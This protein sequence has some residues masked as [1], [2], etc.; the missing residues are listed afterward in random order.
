MVDKTEMGDFQ[1]A[2]TLETLDFYHAL[3]K[4]KC[5]TKSNI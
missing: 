3:A 4:P 5:M 2:Q 1:T